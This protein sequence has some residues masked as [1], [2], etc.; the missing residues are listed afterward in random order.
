MSKNDVWVAFLLNGATVG[1]FLPACC[2]C[3]LLCFI[4]CFYVPFLDIEYF[5]GYCMS[6]NRY[7]NFVESYVHEDRDLRYFY[8]SVCTRKPQQKSHNKTIANWTN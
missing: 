1:P 4:L 2:K 7:A 3:F 5:N 8:L 6:K